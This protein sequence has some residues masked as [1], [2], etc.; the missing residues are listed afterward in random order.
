MLVSAYADDKLRREVAEDRR[1]M[2]EFLLLER[3]FGFE[4]LDWSR[5]RLEPGRS[6][7]RSIRHAAAGLAAAS[8]ADALFSDGEHVGIP[9]GIA[10]RTLGPAKPHVM[11]GHHL[12][13]KTKPWMLR[14]FGRMG[15]SRVLVHSRAQLRFAIDRLGFREGSAA[16]VPYYADTRFWRPQ[17]GAEQ[18]LIASAGREHRDFVTL[19]AAVRELPYEAI[20]ATGSLHSPTATWRTPAVMP[21]NISTGM[22]SHVGLRELYAQ[23]AVVVVPLI[24]NDFQAGVTTILEAMAMAKPVIVTA[25]EG[26]RD[27]VV[28]GVTGVLVSPQDPTALR[29]ELRRLLSDARERRRLGSNA[30]DAVLTHFNLPIYAR[31]LQGHL[32]DAARLR[33]QAA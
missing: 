2:P 4:L 16:F 21:N 31:A 32:L 25:T 22:R 1:P 17:H 8:S 9:L 11:L 5:V 27:V 30:R 15:I 12:S 20:I 19:A 26:Q 24:N 10:L 18:S 6:V 3:E 13:S 7:S 23:A 33:Q 14:S 29:M 28:D